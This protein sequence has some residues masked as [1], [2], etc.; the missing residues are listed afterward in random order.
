MFEF[1][2]HNTIECDNIFSTEIT[3][4]NKLPKSLVGDVG[5]LNEYH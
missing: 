1:L 4:K 5:S 2:L 3:K